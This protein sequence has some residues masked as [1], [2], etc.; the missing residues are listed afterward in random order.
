MRLLLDTH[1]PLW[2][3]ASDQRLGKAD[4]LILGPA[5]RVSAN[6]ASYLTLRA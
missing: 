2:A 6:T 1:I 4:A 5:N 3:L